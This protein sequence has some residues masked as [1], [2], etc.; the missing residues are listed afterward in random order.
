MLSRRFCFF[1]NLFTTVLF[2]GA[3]AQ[4]YLAGAL[5]CTRPPDQGTPACIGQWYPFTDLELV[6]LFISGFAR[7]PGWTGERKSLRSCGH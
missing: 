6:E 2:V 4:P 7:V 5:D 1:K 3:L